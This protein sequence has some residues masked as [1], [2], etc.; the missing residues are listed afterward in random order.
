MA[1]CTV[2]RLLRI[3]PES[4][5]SRLFASHLEGETRFFPSR[6]L[7]H[8]EDHSPG[9]LGK[10][11]GLPR[12]AM[13]G[14]EQSNFLFPMMPTWHRC[15]SFQPMLESL[16]ITLQL[17]LPPQPKQPK[18]TQPPLPQKRGRGCILV[19]RRRLHGR[20]GLVGLGSVDDED[21]AAPPPPATDGH[22]SAAK[23]CEGP[24]HPCAS[25][26]IREP[27]TLRTRRV[28]LETGSEEPKRLK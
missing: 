9:A 26:R 24:A 15:T 8:V 7:D 25:R 11:Q 14:E 22:G 4:E 2:L 18:P 13:Q 5:V 17:I 27:A 21:A 19:G 20:L 10:R 6:S 28:R 16:D 3:R 23:R 1:T 12:R